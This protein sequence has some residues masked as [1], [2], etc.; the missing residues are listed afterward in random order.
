M[1]CQVNPPPGSLRPVR[2]ALSRTLRVRCHPSVR[3]RALRAALIWGSDCALRGEPRSLRTHPRTISLRSLHSSVFL[4]TSVFQNPLL[5]HAGLRGASPGP[6]L[7]TALTGRASSLRGLTRGF[8]PG[9]W[10]WPYRPKS[11]GGVVKTR[12][13]F[14]HRDPNHTEPRTWRCP[15]KTPQ[16]SA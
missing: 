5:L 11:Q 10:S 15:V 9:W 12:L 16:P 4:C 8:T 1:K 3:Q 2:A 13:H 14:D 6:H 7:R